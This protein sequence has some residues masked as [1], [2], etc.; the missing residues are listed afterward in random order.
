MRGVRRRQVRIL[1][2]ATVRGY[3]ARMRGPRR[4][5]SQ[6]L[7]VDS[8]LPEE[9]GF[10]FPT[11]ASAADQPMTSAGNYAEPSIEALDRARAA[12]KTLEL[13]LAEFALEIVPLERARHAGADAGCR[14]SKT[15]VERVELT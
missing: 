8:A 12:A 1:G 10:G 14:L 3:S 2:I 11:L 13:A 7:S 9:S 15:A 6:V 4:P 5:E